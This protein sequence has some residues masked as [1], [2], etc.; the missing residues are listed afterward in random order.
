MPELPSSHHR[1]PAGSIAQR[2]TNPCKW[3]ELTLGVRRKQD[4]P[5][6]AA[7]DGTAIA[8]RRY[9]TRD[10]LVAGYGSDPAAVARI[11]AFAAQH[12]LV[13]TRNDPLSARLTLGGTVCDASR[14]SLATLPT[15]HSYGIV[16]RLGLTTLR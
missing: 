3:I 12:Q 7:L 4:L 5:D 2:K 15:S 13:I 14:A 10:E 6:L 9:L 1:I 11:E 8:A 16:R